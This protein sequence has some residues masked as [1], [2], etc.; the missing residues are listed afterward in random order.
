MIMKDQFVPK[1]SSKSVISIRLEDDLISKMDELSRIQKMS[2]N[3][4][5]RQCIEFALE[6]IDGSDSIDTIS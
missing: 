1:I 5:I 4:F 6:R 3:E 2:R